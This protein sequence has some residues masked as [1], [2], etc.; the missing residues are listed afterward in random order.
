MFEDDVCVDLP[1]VL[2]GRSNY[3]NTT[4]SGL[5]V[6][7]CLDRPEVMDKG[8]DYATALLLEFYAEARCPHVLAPSRGAAVEV[9]G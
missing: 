3:A 5:F 9:Y 1:G 4:F 6:G 7:P 8:L 2:N